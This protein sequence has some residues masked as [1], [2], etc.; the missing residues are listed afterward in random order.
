M[1]TNPVKSPQVL[2]PINPLTGETAGTV[3][4][5]DPDAV[6]A[7]VAKSREAFE[8]WGALTPKQRKPYLR[9]F[10]KHVLRS[11]DRIAAVIRSETG[12]D[13]GDA[14]AEIN[15]GLTA[16][17]YYTRHADELLRPKKGRKWPFLTTKG[18]T[19][20]HPIGVAGI[21]SPWNFPFYLPLLSVTQALSA[22][23]TAVI[24][25]S[26]LTPLSGQLLQDLSIEAGI[27]DDVVQVI[28]GD[29]ATGAALVEADPDM[30]AFT[31]S[32]AVGK[33][34]AASPADVNSWDHTAVL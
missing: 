12:K 28:H 29:G 21:I 13:I 30:I 25:P 24:K 1:T 18:W 3:I 10:A 32:P 4:I 17:D 9:A 20:Y 26:E 23:C 14:M 15:A 2:T 31:G 27:P 34:I 8:S 11:M 5:T 7:V 16:L 19:E 22:G 33:S 6:A